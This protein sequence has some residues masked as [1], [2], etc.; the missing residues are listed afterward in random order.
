MRRDVGPPL[1]HSTLGSERRG[2][3][4][5][6]NQIESGLTLRRRTKG[7]LLFGGRG[8]AWVP[9]PLGRRVP[10]FCTGGIGL[11]P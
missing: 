1:A 10:A 6:D 9:P 3:R 2:S 5:P 8:K 11:Q 7:V 4:T